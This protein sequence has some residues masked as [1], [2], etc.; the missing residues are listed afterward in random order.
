MVHLIP[1]YGRGSLSLQAIM[2]HANRFYDD[3][4]GIPVKTCHHFFGPHG[5]EA[6]HHY[7]ITVW[8]QYI[9]LVKEETTFDVKSLNKLVMVCDGSETQNW[10]VQVIGNLVRRFREAQDDGY[11]G[12]LKTL[13]LVKKSPGHGKVVTKI[14]SLVVRSNLGCT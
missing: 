11:F 12:N 2:T 4:G 9:N 7:T 8:D 13:L 1:Y 10:S 6:N 14:N 3:V 5:S